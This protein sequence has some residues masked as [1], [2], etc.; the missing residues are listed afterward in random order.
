M[1][2]YKLLK[3]VPGHTVDDL[4]MGILD[5]EIQAYFR[6]PEGRQHVSM[7]YTGKLL[8]FA[9]AMPPVHLDS[10]NRLNFHL[11]IL[12]ENGSVVREA[13]FLSHAPI[14]E[15][16]VNVKE[17]AEES[18]RDNESLSPASEAA[19]TLTTIR[20]KE[21]NNLVEIIMAEIHKGVKSIS[22]SKGQERVINHIRF[23]KEAN[24]PDKLFD[25][26]KRKVRSQIKNKY[27][28]VGFK[29]LDRRGK[30]VEEPYFLSK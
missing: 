22:C 19:K 2:D 5:G 14:E 1:G 4:L 8:P 10:D 23:I 6:Y 18:N 12:D 15:I 20:D 26:V 9:L 29:S 21:L 28:D 25:G 11:A 7:G 3:D 30:N 16:R 13:N 24:P 27:G 17:L